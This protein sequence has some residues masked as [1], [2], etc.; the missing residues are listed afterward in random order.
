MSLRTPLTLAALLFIVVGGGWYGWRQF[1]EPFEN[2]FGSPD[3][4]V[5][6]TIAAGDS[7]RRNQVLVNVY[8]AGTRDDLASSTLEDL[9]DIGFLRGDAANA[10]RRVDARVVTVIDKEP[11]SAAV[12]L[13]RAQFQGRVRV[14]ER[15]DLG[16]GVDVV[17]GNGYLGLARHSPRTAPV[18][19][20][21]DICVPATTTSPTG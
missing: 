12:R 19:D 2:P 21:L 5:D 9:V 3:A 20:D 6:E 10:P 17:V 18:R 7:L 8:N 1:E 4:C 14:A 15:P 11:T 16:E 13:V